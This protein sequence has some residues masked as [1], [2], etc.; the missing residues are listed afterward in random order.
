MPDNPSGCHPYPDLVPPPLRHCIFM[1]NALSAATLP[2]YLVLGQTQNNAGLHT[3][4][5]GGL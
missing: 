4:W 5:L 2:I 1:P 3:Q